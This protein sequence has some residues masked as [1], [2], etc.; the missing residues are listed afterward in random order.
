[1]N[2]IAREQVIKINAKYR[3][4]FFENEY[5]AWIQTLNNVNTTHD[6]YLSIMNQEDYI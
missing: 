3:D 1:M 2:I 5:D 6:F 4:F